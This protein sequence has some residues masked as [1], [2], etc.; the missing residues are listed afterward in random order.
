MLYIH[1]C[2]HVV[3]SLS[4]QFDITTPRNGVTGEP[5]LYLQATVEINETKASTR[6]GMRYFLSRDWSQNGRIRLYMRAHQEYG[7]CADNVIR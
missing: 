6:D 2:M 1:I 3:S 5:R 7:S 4:L